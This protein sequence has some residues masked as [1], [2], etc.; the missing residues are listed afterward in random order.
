MPIQ[1]PRAILFD[2]DNTLVDSWPPIHAAMNATLSAMGHAPWSYEETRTR[3]RKSLRDAFPELFGGAWESARD[4]FYESF[5]RTHLDTV[6]T[7]PGVG[8]MLGELRASGIYLGVVSNKMGLYLRREAAYLGLS[9]YF[10]KLVG[11]TDAREDKPAIAPVELALSESGVTRGGEVWFVGDTAIDVQCA[12]N[13]GCVAV[14]LGG[15]DS[16][17]LEFAHH[18]PDLRFGDCAKLVEAVRTA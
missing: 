3:V 11:A 17:P 7:L 9:D 13:A 15:D 5:A 4:V 6:R 1:P 16:Y 18:P 8:D 2:W 12:R 14:V 10:G